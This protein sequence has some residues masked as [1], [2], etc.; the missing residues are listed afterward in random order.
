MIN[1]AV[2]GQ[3]SRPCAGFGPSISNLASVIWPQ[4]VTEHHE[5]IMAGPWT[6]CEQSTH[7]PRRLEQEDDLKGGKPHMQRRPPD[8][9]L[10]DIPSRFLPMGVQSPA[11]S[12]LKEIHLS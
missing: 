5:Q 2:E 4:R 9:C 10:E 12:P 11:L 3:K 7:L 8:F 1:T 6:R